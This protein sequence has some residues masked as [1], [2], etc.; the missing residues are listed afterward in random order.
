MINKNIFLFFCL[1]LLPGYCLSTEI[2]SD[3]DHELLPEIEVV[4]STASES[5]ARNFSGIKSAVPAKEL[6]LFIETLSSKILD[7]LHAQNLESLIDTY[8]SG[9]IFPSE[10]GTNASIILR[11]FS[12]ASFYRNGL[13]H[14]QGSTPFRDV[15]NI[16]S[17]E[18]L[19]G[20]SSA[21]YG[22][23]EPGGTINI[24]TKQPRFESAHSAELT[25]GNYNKVRAELDSTGAI[26]NNRKIAYRIV[27]AYED[28]KSFRDT[29]ESSKIF[30]TPSLS[31]VPND[32]W[33]VLA[34]MEYIQHKTP[35]DTGL[36]A[37]EDKFPL[38]LSRYLGEPKLGQTRSQAITSSLSAEYK[39]AD[40]WNLSVKLLWHNTD[41]DGR[42]AE[43][44]E[45]DEENM[46]GEFFLSRE[47]QR[48]SDESDTF[49]GQLEL[50]KEFQHPGIK[51]RVLT[52]YEFISTDNHIDLDGSDPETD[53]FKINIFDVTYGQL[54]PSLT[55]LR[56]SDERLQQHSFYIQDFISLGEKIKILLGMRIDKM[57]IESRDTVL[58]T[59]INQNDTEISTRAG[60]I[61]A[62]NS[63]FSVFGSYSESSDPNE[64]L[65]PQ[66]E[67]LQPSRGRAYEGGV[68]LNHPHTNLSI[69][70]SFY[71]IEQTNVAVDAPDAPGF[72][73][74]TAIQRSEGV[75]LAL[76]L[77][78]SDWLSANINYLFTDAAIFDDPEIPDGTQ[79]LNVAFHKLVLYSLL[80][81]SLK[82]QNDLQAG[83]GFTYRSQQKASL[84]PEE[85]GIKLPGYWLGNLFINYNYSPRI[86]LGLNINNLLDKKY[87]AASQSDLNHIRPGTP[88]TVI[89][90][91]K[92]SF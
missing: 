56:Q 72:E 16:E 88:L 85:L 15:A 92:L 59:N 8:T 7:N 42:R 11:G 46:S 57:D 70:A 24:T 6:P 65:T 82:R 63:H 26:S 47:F 2:A 69:D 20:A 41:T 21:L 84:D 44:D 66:G 3:N 79:P 1:L 80:S 34:E 9:S 5:A 78:P 35:Y 22:P 73:I 71:S 68:K 87:L 4:E 32:N 55:A 52:G 13:N 30:V 14:S 18:I 75:D 51:Q 45:I 23:G 77:Q 54:L 40:M 53:P 12:D 17:V 25:I 27:A 28:S 31:W 50:S 74:Q 19:K 67:P 38:P 43:P 64:G 62:F 90:S 48:E 49:S 91:F 81:F 33:Q 60:L 10:G 37:I 61:Y 36:I 29:V 86:S 89:G 58:A 39:P 76:S 83:F